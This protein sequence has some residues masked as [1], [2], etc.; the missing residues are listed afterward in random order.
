[1]VPAAPKSRLAA[2]SPPQVIFSSRS[3]EMSP[4]TMVSGQGREVSS[5]ISRVTR[6][7]GPPL[8]EAAAR[9]VALAW[10]F[11]DA[12]GTGPEAPWHVRELL[13]RRSAG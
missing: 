10:A 4:G 7:P 6:G 11:A 2:V 13:A 9:L 3:R 12:R 8:S 5:R 1:M